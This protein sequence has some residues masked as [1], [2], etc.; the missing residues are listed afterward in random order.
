MR[1][2]VCVGMGGPVPVTT[3]QTGADGGGYEKLAGGQEAT[4]RWVKFFK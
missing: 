3:S 2:H 1:V 4:C